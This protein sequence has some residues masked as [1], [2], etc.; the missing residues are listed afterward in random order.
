MNCSPRR[1]AGGRG[2]LRTRP[3]GANRGALSPL[4]RVDAPR[5]LEGEAGE[6]VGLD[7]PAAAHLGVFL[8]GILCATG[9]SPSHAPPPADAAPGVSRVSDIRRLD[10]RDLH[11]VADR[12]G[13]RGLLAG[14]PPSAPTRR[15][16]LPP[17]IFIDIRGAG[18][19]DE[20]L[21][22]RGRGTPTVCFAKSGVGRFDRRDGARGDRTRA[23]EHLPRLR[24]PARSGSSWNIDGEGEIP[25][26]TAACPADSAASCPRPPRS[27][28]RG[29]RRE[30]PLWQPAPDPATPRAGR[31]IDPGPR[32]EG[33]GGDRPTGLKEEDGG[34]GEI[35]RK[36]REKLSASG[37][38]DVRMTRTRT[39]SSRLEER[40]AMAKQGARRHLRLPSHQCQPEPKC[41]GILHLRPSPDERR[42]R[43][44]LELAAREKRRADPQVPG[45]KSSSRQT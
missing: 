17:R 12:H 19:Q 36:I 35:G 8:A 34:V 38:F 31:S 10:E 3:P 9:F 43:E 22:Q 7:T 44:D 24:S 27:R 15:R 20:I 33:S 18:I 28:R 14:E 29:H 32:G 45:V 5:G 11:R 23:G 2:R 39:S 42:N 41:G 13:G 6:R 37:E 25:V 4:E 21:T 1:R 26:P 30:S 16:G 40:T